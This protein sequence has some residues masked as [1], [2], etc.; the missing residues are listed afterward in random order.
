MISLKFNEKFNDNV[1]MAKSIRVF[2]SKA[3]FMLIEALALVV[4]SMILSSALD[5]AGRRVLKL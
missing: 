1:S 3:T 2:V 5:E 4:L